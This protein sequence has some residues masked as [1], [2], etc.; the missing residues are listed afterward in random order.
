MD[1]FQEMVEYAIQTHDLEAATHWQ[2]LAG[3]S[4]NEDADDEDFED[5]DDNF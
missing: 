4:E 5:E 2:S 1:F 3:V